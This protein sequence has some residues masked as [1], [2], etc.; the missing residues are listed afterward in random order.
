MLTSIS[1]FYYMHINICI[2]IYQHSPTY[3]QFVCCKLDI[4]DLCTICDHSEAHINA[5]GSIDTNT[6]VF[7]SHFFLLFTLDKYF[8]VQPPLHVIPGLRRNNFWH[9]SLQS[10]LKSLLSEGNCNPVDFTIFWSNCTT[11]V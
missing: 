2:K 6:Y 8:Q 1:L 4:S 11:K 9:K 10:A 3:K 7:I 5:H